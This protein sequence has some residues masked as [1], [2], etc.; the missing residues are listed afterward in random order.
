VVGPEGGID[1]L[2]AGLRLEGGRSFPSS[3]RLELVGDGNRQ[4]SVRLGCLARV[5]LGPEGAPGVRVRERGTVRNEGQR[6][7]VIVNVV[8]HGHRGERGHPARARLLSPCAPRRC[9]P[10][11]PC[12]LRAA[13]FRSAPAAALLKCPPCRGERRTPRTSLP[14]MVLSL[15]TAR[16]VPNR[17]PRCGSPLQL[18][19]PARRAVS[20]PRSACSPAP[21][22]EPALAACRCA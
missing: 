9:R 21:Q 1:E 7:G 15:R 12:L 14:V 10:V 3:A 8:H 13:S 17:G 19:W 4:G 2:H 18:S 11:S 16:P 5:E 22:G 6:D 20:E